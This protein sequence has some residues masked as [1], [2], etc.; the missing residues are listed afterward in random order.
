M[1]I[2]AAVP[3]AAGLLIGLFWQPVGIAASVVFGLLLIGAVRFHA[4]AGDYANAKTRGNAMAPAADRRRRR[5]C[6]HARILAR[7]GA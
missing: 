4:K 5:C 6:H 7:R 2:S 3:S 1:F